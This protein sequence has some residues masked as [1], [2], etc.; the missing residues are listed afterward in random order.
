MAIFVN[1][2]NK[3]DLAILEYNNNELSLID[4]RTI[5]DYSLKYSIYNIFLIYNPKKGLILYHI[6]EDSDANYYIYINHI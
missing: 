4:K 3:I 1:F 6:K 5:I 2:I